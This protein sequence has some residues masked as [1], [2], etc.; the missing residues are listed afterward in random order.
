[1]WCVPSTEVPVSQMRS[2]DFVVLGSCALVSK[3]RAA[4]QTCR[5]RPSG[6]L[7]WF[8]GVAVSATVGFSAVRHAAWV[9]GGAPERNFSVPDVCERATTDLARASQALGWS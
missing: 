8:L 7:V 2:R 5:S 9:S 3:C 4:V 1:M 6:R